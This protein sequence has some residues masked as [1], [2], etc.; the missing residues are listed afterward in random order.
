MSRGKTT[1]KT[2]TNNISKDYII[3][4][5]AHM[6]INMADTMATSRQER[7]KA[8]DQ[9]TERLFTCTVCGKGFA[10]EYKLN[11]HSKNHTN[12]VLYQCE[13]C[14]R[15]FN[16]KSTLNTHMKNN[17]WVMRKVRV[18]A[19]EVATVSNC[20][21]GLV[22]IHQRDHVRRSVYQHVGCA[23]HFKQFHQQSVVDPCFA[24]FLL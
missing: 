21:C 3:F 5:S 4:K 20:F 17:I 8:P 1:T 7:D 18:T 19:G 12:D 24:V 9:P 22:H 2:K 23:A 15:T 6:Y 11:R 16:N 13:T 14:A 10:K